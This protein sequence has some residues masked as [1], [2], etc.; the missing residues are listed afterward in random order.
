MSQSKFKKE[1]KAMRAS[2]VV[3]KQ[4]QEKS[5]EK[6]NIQPPDEERKVR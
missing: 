1:V 4:K 6:S 3:E 2:K 5:L